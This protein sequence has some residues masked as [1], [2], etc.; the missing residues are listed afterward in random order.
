M[1]MCVMYDLLLHNGQSLVPFY[2][3]GTKVEHY[4][5]R[6]NDKSCVTVD[7]EEY[8]ENLIKFVEVCRFSSQKT[9]TFEF[10]SGFD[11]LAMSLQL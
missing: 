11:Q 4:R 3:C 2:S 6:R 9:V 7:D 10:K 1:F 8:F 5:L